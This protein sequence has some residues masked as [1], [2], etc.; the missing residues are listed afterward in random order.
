MHYVYVVRNLLDN[1]AYIGKTKDPAKRKRDHFYAARKG[2]HRPLYVAIRDDGEQN[3]IF[4]ILE[5]CVN[6][7]VATEREKFWIKKHNTFK[8]GYNLTPSGGFHVGNKGRRFSQDHRRK[9]SEAHKGKVF[10]EETRRKIKV[11]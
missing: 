9:I 2:D 3:F 1:M 11:V 6:D 8:N 10:S 4:E 5:E 7:L